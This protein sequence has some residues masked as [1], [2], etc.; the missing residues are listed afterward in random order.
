MTC[1]AWACLLTCFGWI[2]L[3]AYRS[4]AAPPP[5]PATQPRTRAAA[6]APAALR[7]AQPPT[8][9]ATP[10]RPPCSLGR[11][12]CLARTT[13]GTADWA[14]PNWTVRITTHC[15]L[16]YWVWLHSLARLRCPPPC[17]ASAVCLVALAGW[18]AFFCAPPYCLTC[19][20]VRAFA[21]CCRLCVRAPLAPLAA[22]PH[23]QRA[24][25][26]AAIARWLLGCLARTG[27]Q[28][29]RQPAT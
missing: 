19:L 11:T 12:A 23:H 5:A 20:C 27:W 26:A 8:Q 3:A 29:R 15:L 17:L 4:C 28:L 7:P 16:T 24:M 25:H 2:A 22:A 13:H 18:L 9:V 1:D 10:C 14:V 6:H 21:L